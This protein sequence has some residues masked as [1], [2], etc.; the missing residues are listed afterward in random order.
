MKIRLLDILLLASVLAGTHKMYADEPPYK[1]QVLPVEE[2]V[3][4]LLGR[5][6]LEE[7]R[8]SIHGQ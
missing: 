3:E 2:R 5:M 1:N 8:F 6:T 7:K 4:D